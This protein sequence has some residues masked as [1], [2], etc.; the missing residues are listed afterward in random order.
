V[1]KLAA[2]LIHLLLIVAVV[3]AAVHFFR[4]RSA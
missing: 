2:G 3:F 1:F 4:K